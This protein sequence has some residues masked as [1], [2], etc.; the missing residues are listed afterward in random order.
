VIAVGFHVV[1]VAVVV[2]GCAAYLYALRLLA[3]P[4]LT[5]DTEPDIGDNQ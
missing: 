1:I 2:G 5:G 3:A 4:I